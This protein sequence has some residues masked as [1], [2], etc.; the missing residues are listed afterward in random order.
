LSLLHPLHQ[1]LKL[2][3]GY[4][5]IPI[6]V[7]FLEHSFDGGVVNSSDANIFEQRDNFIDGQ[8]STTVSVIL[9]E[10]IEKY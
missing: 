1:I 3:E 5:P 7:Y 8:V 10:L 6:G 2:R 9:S 4:P